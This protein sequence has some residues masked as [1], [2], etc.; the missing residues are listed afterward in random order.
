M[1]NIVKCNDCEIKIINEKELKAIFN[2]LTPNLKWHNEL[3]NFK[4]GDNQSFVFYKENCKLV[5]SLKNRV[6]SEYEW[7]ILGN[8]W[9]DIS[10]MLSF[11]EINQDT[12]NNYDEIC[13]SL[14]PL[15]KQKKEELQSNF[16][17]EDK[18]KFTNPYAEVNRLFAAK[19]LDKLCPIINDEVLKTIFKELKK[20]GLIFYENKWKKVIEGAERHNW[21]IRSSLMHK[22]GKQYS[23]RGNDDY[24]SVLPWTL[25][26]SFTANG[27][28]LNLLK[29]NKNVILTGA[30]GTGKTYNA[31]QIAN[32]FAGENHV[33]LVQFH[34]SYDYT[35]FV[36]GLRPDNNHSF[37]RVDGAFK[38]FC[39][40]AILG[41]DVTASEKEINDKT[42]SLG[43]DN[44]V[45]TETDGVVD[46]EKYPYVFIIDE[47]NRGEI[48]K[49]FGELF[50]CVEAGHRGEDERID[51]QY[52]NLL[53]EGDLFKN[54][55]FVPSNVYIIGTMNDIDRSVE[56][57][58]FAFRRRFAFYDVNAT[59]D[60]LDSMD[61]DTEKVEILK[62]RMNSLN[63]EIVKPEFGLS[64]A[65]QLGGAYFLK[66]KEYCDQEDGFKP[67]WNYHLQGL[68]YEY[69]RGLPADVVKKNME[70]LEKAYN[71]V[72]TTKKDNNQ[73]P[74]EESK[75]EQ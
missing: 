39:K 61:I 13:G 71:S 52:Q 59:S 43:A 60:M 3:K 1:V 18:T 38:R 65:Y 21:L 73:V 41:L 74:Q 30:P 40:C 57:M 4:E 47:I 29:A 7:D 56:S 27:Q 49:I 68:L 64:A 31:Q 63:S 8:N 67:L 42:V 48:S 51:T 17:D 34:P 75:E 35:D 16:E 15:L 5:S 19:N 10:K 72:G 32:L 26:I 14:F 6:F 44:S 45:D 62:K 23:K 46:E 70:K 66:F 53:Q 9:N 69:F 11:N 20:R 58:D 50:F 25:Y 55:F 22:I 54:G 36:E 33:K 37:S 12:L 24:S 28:I 2:S